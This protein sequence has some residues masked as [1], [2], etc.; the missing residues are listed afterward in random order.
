MKLKIDDLSFDYTSK[1]ILHNV[2]F[3]AKH[4]EIL[5]ILG[6]NGCGKTTLLKCINKLLKPQ[7]GHVL[8]SDLNEQIL[9]SKS[10]G[11]Y[12]T[13]GQIDIREMNNKEIARSMA[14]VNQSEYISFPFTALEAVRMGRYAS[15]RGN[16]ESQEREIVYNAMKDAGAL[17]FSERHVNELSGGELRRVMI[18]RALAQQ[19]DILLLDEPTLHLD[20]CHQFELMDLVRKLTK[21]RHLMVVMITHDMMFAARYCDRIILMQNGSIV[22]AGKTS[23][24]MTPENI[25]NIFHI[26]AAIDYDE[27]IGGLNVTMIRRCASGEE[28]TAR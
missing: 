18:A 16:S 4:G 17:E 10:L 26:E 1:S 6:E 14:V 12:N 7:N 27:R 21:E 11:N 20:V 9:D 8:I 15:N 22:E 28:E 19:S 3:E 25:R 24:V 5:G 2:T 13:A 23:D